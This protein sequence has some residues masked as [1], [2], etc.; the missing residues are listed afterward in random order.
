MIRRETAK[1]VF[2]GEYNASRIEMK[3]EGEGSP[4]Y[5]LTP[6]GEKVNRIFIVG[7][8]T[9]VEPVGESGELYR[10][11]ISDPTGVFSLYSGQYQ[12]EVTDALSSIEPPAYVAVVGKSRVYE[13]EPGQIYV[14]VRPEAVRVVDE[15]LRNYWVLETCKLTKKRLGAMREAAL[16]ESPSVEEMV[17][18]SYSPELAANACKAV[19]CYD[20]LDLGYYNSMLADAINYLS[21]N[22]QIENLKRDE[23]IVIRQPIDRKKNDAAPIGHPETFEESGT[24]P[25]K[26]QLPAAAPVTPDNEAEETRILSI[27]SELGG[28]RGAAWDEVVERGMDGG[29]DRFAVEE[30]LTS[31]MDKGL[32]Y[33]PTLGRL[34][35]A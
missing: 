9:D 4:S 19:E 8:L 31:L 33:E 26:E 6:L 21:P 3:D 13:P 20:E 17:K 18:L 1:R 5:V 10:A 32:I 7:V 16:M 35:R 22:A 25:T 14:S 2:A 27:I 12:A 30:V 11:R 24:E 15:N 34:R 23:R 29:L 28:E